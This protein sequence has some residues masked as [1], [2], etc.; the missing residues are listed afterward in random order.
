MKTFPLRMDDQLHRALKHAALDEGVT[1]HEWI[2][3]ILKQR[4]Q[5]ER[6]ALYKDK[7]NKAA[8]VN[9]NRK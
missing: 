8:R 5:Y 7:S 2:L 1:L 3:R 6:S 9:R 4:L